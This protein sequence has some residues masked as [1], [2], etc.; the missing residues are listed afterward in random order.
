MA[1]ILVLQLAGIAAVSVAVLLWL[2]SIPLCVGMLLQLIFTLAGRNS[3]TL[4]L[5][6]ILAGCGAVLSIFFLR[7]TIPMLYL[8]LYWLIYYL[9]LW[10]V[11]LVV[12][13][14]QKSIA[15]WRASR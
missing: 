5:P 9:C 11:W 12:T 3:W 10:L 13:Q 2:I 8:G 4:Y 14:I 1:M 7:E 15:R 6:A